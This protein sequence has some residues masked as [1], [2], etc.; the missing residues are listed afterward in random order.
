MN[1]ACRIEAIRHLGRTISVSTV[2][3]E[4]HHLVLCPKAI[5]L[6]PIQ[7]ILTNK[8][9]NRPS[10]LRRF[11]NRRPNITLKAILVPRT[12]VLGR[13]IQKPRL[14][15]KSRTPITTTRCFF[16]AVGEGCGEG[17]SAAPALGG[18]KAVSDAAKVVAEVFGLTGRRRQC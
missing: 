1:W 17:L 7:T 13:D 2:Y 12:R 10:P 16:A 11:P 8:N 9:K 4:H 5:Y 15:T 3:V 18:G 14:G 6:G